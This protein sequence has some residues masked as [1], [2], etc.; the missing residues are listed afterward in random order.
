MIEAVSVH[1]RNVI[2]FI[3]DTSDL[4]T[5]NS[6]KFFENMVSLPET[7]NWPTESINE[8]SDYL[9]KLLEIANQ[10]RDLLSKRGCDLNII[11]EYGV[12]SLKNFMVPPIN[13]KKNHANVELWKR[14]FHNIERKKIAV[15]CRRECFQDYFV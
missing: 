12:T 15:T 8:F 6:L 1:Y 14:V 9:V 7:Q 3:S 2:V 11:N 10:F 5:L 4:E 13:K